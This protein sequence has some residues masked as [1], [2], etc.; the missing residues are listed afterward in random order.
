MNNFFKW[1][2]KIPIFFL[3]LLTSFVV[4]LNSLSNGFVIDDYEVIVNN[5]I[6]H[7]FKNI[8][9][10]FEGGAFSRGSS[11]QLFGQYYRPITLSFF[12]L[13][14]SFF[15][16]R[17]IYFH[18][19]Q[20]I[21]FSINSFLIFKVLNNFFDKKLSF[22]LSLLFLVHPM[23]STT[24]VFIGSM[25]DVLFFIFGFLGILLIIKEQISFKNII[26]A[27]I[28]F[29]LS[30]LSKE[31]GI[32][33]F[34][35]GLLAIFVFER[36]YFLKTIFINFL[37]IFLYSI[38]RIS[39]QGMFWS[40]SSFAPI[41]KLTLV[42]KILSLPSILGYYFIELLLPFNLSM[43]QHW[44][45]NS[46][47]FVNFIIPLTL[48][49][50]SIIG[51]AVF[52][53]RN[54][55]DYKTKIFFLLWF[56]IGLIAVLPFVPIDMTVSDRWFGF[57]L[58]GLM[59][60]FALF[61]ENLRGKFK[62]RAL[63][64]LLLVTFLF[65]IRTFIRNFDWKNNLILSARDIK[66]SPDSFELQNLYGIELAKSGKVKEGQK[67]LEKSVQI[68]PY[69][70]N[71]N[72]LASIYLAQGKT[73]LAIEYFR[74]SAEGFGY[75]KAYENLASIYMFNKDID[76]A[77]SETKKFIEKFPNNPKLWQILALCEL[78]A[79][80]SKEAIRAASNYFNLAKTKDSLN[81]L[82]SIKA[83]K[84]Y[85]EVLNIKN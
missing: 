73:D 62:K 37:I 28:L 40:V 76:F 53:K 12:S 35:L 66:Y 5:Q 55:G 27:S 31:S 60:I 18:F 7:S 64:V 2:N 4:F 61:I 47:N 19:F 6:V 13:L 23:N 54:V 69:G 77:I 36:K 65:S 74:K 57:S 56:L 8:P 30:L 34:L 21:L 78:K 32:L 48:V 45:I 42:G 24:V 83:G 44:T 26:L 52:L 1:L 84:T 33:F 59:G 10:F 25:A 3:I 80:D 81:L 82:N 38:F 11:T 63:T 70:L 46:P 16:N 71:L 67:H 20:I 43:F 14:Y 49:S 39:S 17:A 29:L 50:A 68:L 58:V 51:L 85:K 22:I 75:Y 15:G 9:V 41:Q 79:G 72:N